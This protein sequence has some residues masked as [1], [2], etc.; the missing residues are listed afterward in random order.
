MSSSVPTEAA[1]APQAAVAQVF[2]GSIEGRKK[3]ELAELCVALHIDPKGKSKEV[4]IKLLND[5][6][7]VDFTSYE[8]DPV[9]APLYKYRAAQLENP[10]R[11][12][13]NKSKS[14]RV[15]TS[16]RAEEQAEETKAPKPLTGANLKL[17][18]VAHNGIV[19]V[20]VAVTGPAIEAITS[21]NSRS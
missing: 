14:L 5:T 4:L 3:K 21:G 12:G 17:T 13:K 2:E 10:Q 20:T 7:F 8:D 1:V 11:K 18:S 15:S 16:K 6:L 9:F 19:T